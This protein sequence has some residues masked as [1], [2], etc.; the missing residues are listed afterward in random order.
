MTALFGIT[1][2][3]SSTSEKEYFTI[4]LIPKAP[5]NNELAMTLMYKSGPESPV[6]H[7]YDIGAYAFGND[8]PADGFGGAFSPRNVTDLSGYIMTSGTL[9]ISESSAA[10][11]SG[12]FEM[13]G[14]YA[15]LAEQDSTRMVNINGKFYATPW[16]N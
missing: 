9:S 10:R 13:S 12:E 16:P 14:H 11:I 6:V 15:R 7:S 5:G 1:T 3:T 2:Y 4:T 8:I